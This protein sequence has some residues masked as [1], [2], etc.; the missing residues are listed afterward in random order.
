MTRHIK[1]YPVY[2]PEDCPNRKQING[3][4]ICLWSKCR[5]ECPYYHEFPRWCPLVEIED[6]MDD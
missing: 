1:L 3:K 5:Y 4:F 2:G 6:D